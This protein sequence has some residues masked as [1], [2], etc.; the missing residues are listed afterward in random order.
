MDDLTTFRTDAL[1]NAAIL[2]LLRSG[3]FELRREIPWSSNYAFLGTV[4]H[5]GREAVVV[6]KPGQGEN[7]LWDFPG[8]NLYKREESAFLVSEALG[9]QLVP[10]TVTREGD[11]GVGMVQLYI[12]HDP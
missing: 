12:E 2:E 9:W 4:C 10:P 1:G 11:F 3:T 6:Y 7:P 8:G 5:N